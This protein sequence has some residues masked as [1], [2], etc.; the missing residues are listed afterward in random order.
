[1]SQTTD[2]ISHHVVMQT[3]FSEEFALFCDAELEKR[4]N[5]GEDFDV[6]AYRE[7]IEMVMTKLQALEAE[8]IA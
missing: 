5:S 3:T 2:T 4:L 7:A 8:E 1:M 6:A